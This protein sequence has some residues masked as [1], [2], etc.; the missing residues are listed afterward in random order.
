MQQLSEYQS[1]SHWHIQWFGPRLSLPLWKEKAC[2]WSQTFFFSG[3]DRTQSTS[4]SSSV[5][6][7][8]LRPDIGSLL[9]Y[10]TITEL[11]M[12]VNKVWSN[13]CDWLI[14]NDLIAT[15]SNYSIHLYLSNIGF[16]ALVTALLLMH[17]AHLRFL[18][19]CEIRARY[20]IQSR[21]FFLLSTCTE[22]TKN[23]CQI[24]SFKDM[25]LL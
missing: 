8:V 5:N 10:R 25:S 22:D 1:H 4:V 3:M 11:R 23:N 13:H 20:I 7:S 18:L 16:P 21:I 24:F 17:K 9:H 2:W 6:I 12:N 14:K 15:S 19:P